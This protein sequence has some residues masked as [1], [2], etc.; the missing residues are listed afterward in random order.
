MPVVGI[1]EYDSKRKLIFLD[2]ESY[3]LLYKGEVRRLN[4]TE[5]G[6][7][8]EGRLAQL[9]QELLLPRARSYVIHLLEKQERTRRQIER[10]LREHYYPDHIA[11]RA[12]DYWQERGYI[13]DAAYAERFLESRC[14]RYSYRELRGKLMQRGIAAEVIAQAWDQVAAMEAAR[15]DAQ[16]CGAQARLQREALQKA[17]EKKCRSVDPQKAEGRGKLIRYLMGK[18]FSFSDIQN[19]LAHMETL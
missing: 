16:P 12:V 11:A 1:A 14:R 17:I 19:E 2:G 7:L 6:E 8:E 3:C 15:E 9:D 4:L 18:G 5:G 13:D 10:K